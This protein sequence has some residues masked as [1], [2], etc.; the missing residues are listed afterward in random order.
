MGKSTILMLIKEITEDVTFIYDLP[1]SD[2]RDE[3]VD[4]VIRKSKG[5]TELLKASK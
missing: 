1:H 5:L 4:N 3:A 2:G